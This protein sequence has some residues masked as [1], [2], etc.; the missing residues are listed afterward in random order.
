M[1]Y[2]MSYYIAD[3]IRVIL[4]CR[5]YT[6]WT[7]KKRG[8]NQKLNGSQKVVSIEIYVYIQSAPMKGRW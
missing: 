1:S 2:Y 5:Q 6:R 4:H 8:R 3:N 7:Y